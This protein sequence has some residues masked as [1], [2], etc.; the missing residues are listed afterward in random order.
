LSI[1]K[2]NVFFDLFQTSHSPGQMPVPVERQPVPAE[3]GERGAAAA[4]L[5]GHAVV[6]RLRAL[7]LRP[8][9]QLLGDRLLDALLRPAQTHRAVRHG[10]PG[11]AQ[12][13]RHLPPLVP[14]HLGAGL[15]LARAQ[16]EGAMTSLKL[17]IRPK[18][19]EL[20]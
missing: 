3:P 6:A 19:F 4:A 20:N 1:T 8:G 7:D 9:L 12:A 10:L 2:N 18:K 11:A 14:P 15:H 17:L 16:G 5:C 13:A